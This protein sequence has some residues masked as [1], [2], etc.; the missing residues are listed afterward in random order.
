MPLTWQL[1]KQTDIPPSLREAVGGH[2]LVARLL[3]QRVR[4]ERKQAKLLE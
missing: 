2:P 3:A 4:D 1:A